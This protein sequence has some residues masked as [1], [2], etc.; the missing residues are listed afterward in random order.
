MSSQTV[1]I[2]QILYDQVEEQY[3][4]IKKR[5]RVQ[6]VIKFI[7]LVAFIVS[8]LTLVFASFYIVGDKNYNIFNMVQNHNNKE[9]IEAQ[10]LPAI[11]EFSKDVW[12]SDF[13]FAFSLWY[14]AIK[15]V[16]IV[17]SFVIGV[18]KVLFGGF[19]RLFSGKLTH[20]KKAKIVEKYK[21]KHS[22]T[23]VKS[24][25]TSIISYVI[26]LIFPTVADILDLKD[27]ATSIILPIIYSVMV[28]VCFFVPLSSIGS[29]VLIA[30]QVLTVDMKLIFLMTATG[31]LHTAMIV[32]Q[33]VV[34]LVYNFRKLK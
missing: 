29:S 10:I 28:V 9:S 12:L 34:N 13:W 19:F 15:S 23:F 18:V 7:S 33:Y 8:V 32:L 5:E 24:I 27:N 4:K 20:E 25:I 16:S 2:D 30:G 26:G 21:K 3:N 6:K 1:E 31:V 14:V 11:D 17:I 22:H